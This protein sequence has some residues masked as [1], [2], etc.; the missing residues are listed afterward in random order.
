M[1]GRPKLEVFGA[2][3]PSDTLVMAPA[4][5]EEA[6]LASFEAGYTAGWEDAMAAQA[7]EQGRISADLARN[8]QTLSFTYHEA[9]MHVLTALRPLFAAL[10]GTLLPA[11]AREA[12][13]QT[14]ADQL[15]TLADT[16]AEA[17]VVIELNPA[18][19]P[20]VESLLEG[21][22]A[23]PVRLAEVPSLGEGQVYLRLGVA[24]VLVDLDRALAEIAAAVTGYFQPAEEAKDG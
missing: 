2:E 1:T 11:V 4:D 16:L 20:A 23:P 15:C 12:L 22:A 13:A 7:E 14:V 17:P 18:A 24:E 3:V 19:R 6:R 5:L 10:V 9:R 21:R 8:L